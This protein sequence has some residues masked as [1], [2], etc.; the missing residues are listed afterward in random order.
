M[1]DPKR[2]IDRHN[3][4]HD[5]DSF[6]ASSHMDKIISVI[7]SSIRGLI[8]C[9]AGKTLETRL[10]AAMRKISYPRL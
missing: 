9:V 3:V 5:S 4:E 1:H 10:K 7:G 6:K 2:F 8:P